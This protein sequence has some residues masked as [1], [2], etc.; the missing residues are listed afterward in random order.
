[1]LQYN[2]RQTDDNRLKEM[3]VKGR[4]LLMNC[5]EQ[6]RIQLWC[7]RM[8]ELIH[9]WESIRVQNSRRKHKAQRENLP[10]ETLES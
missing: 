4:I 3:F 5:N 6:D 9:N 10:Q 7:V 1:M 8:Q 2:C